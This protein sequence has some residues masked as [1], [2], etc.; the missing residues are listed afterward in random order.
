MPKDVKPSVNY[1]NREFTSIR[2]ELVEF[3]KRYYADSFQDFNQSSFG[4]LM[5]DTVAY[6]GDVLSFYLDYQATEAFLDS[7]TETNNILRHGYRMGYRHKP[8]ASTAFG[9]AAFYC[10]CPA[11]ANGL[12]PDTRYL[13]TLQEGSTFRSSTGLSFILRHDV[14]FNLTTNEIVVARVSEDTGTPE[15]YAVKSYGQVMSGKYQSKTF[16]IGNF[17]KFNLLSINDP[18][19]QEVISAVDTEG[20]EYYEVDYLSQNVVYKSFSN[21]DSDGFT[22]DALLKPVVAPRRFITTRRDNTFYLQFGY[23]S[24][25]EVNA[26][27]LAEPTD[28]ALQLHGREYVSDSAFDPSKLTQTDKFGIAPSNTKLTVRYRTLDSKTAGVGVGGLNK[29]GKVRLKFKSPAGLATAKTLTVRQSIEIYNEEPIVGGSVNDVSATE[30][31]R[32]I[33]DQFS[34]QNRAVTKQDYEALVYNMPSKF[35]SVKRCYIMRDNDSFKRNLNLYVI[36]SHPSGHFTTTADAV[37]ENLKIWLN[38]SRMIGDTIDILDA[39]VVNLGIEFKVKAGFEMS[40][41]QVLLQCT[42]AIQNTIMAR[43]MYIGESFPISEVFRTLA[44]VPGVSDVVSVKIVKKAGLNRYS[45]INF[46]VDKNTTPDARYV[47]CPKNVVF[48][49]KYPA[50]DIIGTVI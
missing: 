44:K 9:T 26:P 4:S 6:V 12:G 3:A 35:G 47:A 24:T 22:P 28:V 7:A 17:Q 21:P 46:N 5:I 45:D 8:R 19:L 10:L 25:E 1:T 31:R 33:Y 50:E 29:T 20:N 11:K 16:T 32:N 14:N 37:K 23:G 48:E 2:G 27:S 36:S 49:V 43:K 13:P 38:K 18:N 39:K 42:Q 15:Y 34:A 41:T 30:L 40:T